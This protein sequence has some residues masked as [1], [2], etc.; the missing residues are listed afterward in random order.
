MENQNETDVAERNLDHE[1]NDD[2]NDERE[3]VVVQTRR[4]AFK[5]YTFCLHNPEVKLM[6]YVVVSERTRLDKSNAA[7]TKQFTIIPATWFVREEALMWYPSSCIPTLKGNKFEQ[8]CDHLILEKHSPR[9]SIVTFSFNQNAKKKY[10]LHW[11]KDVV[12]AVYGD[13]GK[14]KYSA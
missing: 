7:Y 13:F 10:H 8:L 2:D 1:M 4:H 12:K 5:D 14:C 3:Y 9:L 11:T 6:D